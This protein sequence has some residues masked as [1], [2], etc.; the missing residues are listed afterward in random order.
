MDKY[1]NEIV[2]KMQY[3]ECDCNELHIQLNESNITVT[4]CYRNEYGGC[5]S[6]E[7]TQN[8]D[9]DDISKECVDY[10]FLMSDRYETDTLI[11]NI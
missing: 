2:N 8:I 10:L 9:Y 7:D 6:N 1:F 4:R 3:S 5:Y 11:L